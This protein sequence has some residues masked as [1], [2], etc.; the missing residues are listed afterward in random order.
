M[1]PKKKLPY[2][3]PTLTCLGKVSEMTF[4]GSIPDAGP[5]ERLKRR[6]RVEFDKKEEEFK[7]FNEKKT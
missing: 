4:V 7:A 5:L 1:G 3:K 6:E 2:K